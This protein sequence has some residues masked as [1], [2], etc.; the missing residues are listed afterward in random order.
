[1]TAL[2]LE[3]FCILSTDLLLVIGAWTFLIVPFYKKF[4]G[5]K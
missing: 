2:I 4:K 5:G 3:W 1:M